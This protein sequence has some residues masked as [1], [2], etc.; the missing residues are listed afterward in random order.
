MNFLELF[1][2]AFMTRT[3]SADVVTFGDIDPTDSIQ[4]K[5]MLEL[6]NSLRDIWLDN[7]S[8]FEDRIAYMTCVV[9]QANYDM[10]FDGLLKQDGIY[11]QPIDNDNNPIGNKIPLKWNPNYTKILG[12]PDIGKHQGQPNEYTMFNDQ[13]Y[14]YPAPDKAYRVTCLY[15]S[16]KWAISVMTVTT[17]SYAGTKVLHVNSTVEA[18]VGDIVIINKGTPTEETGVI[19]S[20][21]LGQSYNFVGN[22]TFDHQVGERVIIE[23]QSMQY[24]NDEPNWVSEY[25]YIL[26]Y[27]CLEK[28]FYN[29]PVRQALYTKSCGSSLAS[30][31]TRLAGTQ[32]NGPRIITVSTDWSV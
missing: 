25:H 7:T 30:M 12:Q 17:I 27:H 19:A 14:L 1:K 6:N 4:A 11:I 16:V 23:T 24:E 13:F 15:E 3:G 22:L 26:V 29:D 18:T 32:D 9:G 2:S 28:M 10:P 31:L 20:I 21:Q 8:L 5:I